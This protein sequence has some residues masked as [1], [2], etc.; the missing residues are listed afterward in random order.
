MM[1]FNECIPVGWKFC[2]AERPP[3]KVKVI[4]TKI[5]YAPVIGESINLDYAIEDAL[6]LIYK[7]EPTLENKAMFKVYD[8]TGVMV[9][10]SIPAGWLFYSADFIK[11]VG[12]VHLRSIVYPEKF[13]YGNG[14]S[15]D[16]AIANAIAMVYTTEG[17]KVE[18]V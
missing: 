8:A 4:F 13:I 15:L 6:T 16:G 11:E 14:L 1:N 7:L 9:D 10:E 5:G 2:S 12:V 3:G 17:T 18:K